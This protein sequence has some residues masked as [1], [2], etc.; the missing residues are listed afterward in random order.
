MKRKEDEHDV[1]CGLLE[2][3]SGKM[4]IWAKRKAMGG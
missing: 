2:A 3:I 1:I 4:M